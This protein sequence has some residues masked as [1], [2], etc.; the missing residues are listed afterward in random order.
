MLV[1]IL[2][3]YLPKEMKNLNPYLGPAAAFFDDTVARK[4]DP[5]LVGRLMATKPQLL[6]RYQLYEAA[7]AINNLESIHADPAF[8]AIGTDCKAVYKY[9]SLAIRNFVEALGLLQPLSVRYRCQYC[10]VTPNESLDH[11]LPQSIYG[12]YSINPLNLVPACKTCNGYKSS[13]FLVNGQRQFINHYLDQ[14]PQVQYL[15]AVII[16]DANGD[17]D[18][19]FQLENRNNAI[20]AGIFRLI[21]EH[22][23]R[24]R[25][26][27]RMR[28][29]ASTDI[30]EF[31]ELIAES[32]QRLSLQDTTEEVLRLIDKSRTA[33]GINFYMAVLKEAIITDASFTNR[34]QWN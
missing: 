16:V 6:P 1:Y 32:A 13:V 8:G 25:L 22:F 20:P 12:E 33:Y 2:K 30:S 3:A 18:F 24:L 11:Y 9:D 27:E 5:A 19:R 23:K 21:N 14:L 34:F 26:L 28:K 7:F 17:I 4:E 29:A 31:I 10:T 15:F